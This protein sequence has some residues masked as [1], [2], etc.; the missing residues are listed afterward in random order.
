ME[1]HKKIEDDYNNNQQNPGPSKEAREENSDKPAGRTVNWAII[2]A[3]GLLLIVAF[4]YYFN[5]GN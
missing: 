4:I 1:D 3:V 5:P 2:I